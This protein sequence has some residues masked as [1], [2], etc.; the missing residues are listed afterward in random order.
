MS[1]F[2]KEGELPRK[3]RI[4]LGVMM[5]GLYL[6]GLASNDC[7]RVDEDCAMDNSGVPRDYSQLTE[8][9]KHVIAGGS[10]F[11]MFRSVE[12]GGDP[13]IVELLTKKD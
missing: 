10:P 5:Y 11:D 12:A 9:H 2:P 7:E 6:L 8:Q 3:D 13:K 4:R 1:D